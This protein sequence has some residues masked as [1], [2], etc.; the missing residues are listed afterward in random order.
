[1]RAAIALSCLLVAACGAERD[2][3]S[4]RVGGTGSSGPVSATDADPEQS[5]T[6][7]GSVS[8]EP[9]TILPSDF[10]ACGA[11]VDDACIVGDDHGV[12]DYNGGPMM[13]SY[14]V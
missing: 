4:G 3:S 7:T 2:G 11:E 13:C 5:E 6:S 10:A 8:E 9:E 1:M 12:P 14:E